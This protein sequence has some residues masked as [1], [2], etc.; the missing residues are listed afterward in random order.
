MITFEELEE[1]I[2][3]RFA[4]GREEMVMNMYL[5]Q[6]K[7]CPVFIELKPEYSNVDKYLDLLL[8]DTAM[9]DKYLERTGWGYVPEKII[10]HCILEGRVQNCFIGSKHATHPTYYCNLLAEHQQKDILFT[11]LQKYVDGLLVIDMKQLVIDMKQLSCKAKDL[12]FDKNNNA[13]FYFNEPEQMEYLKKSKLGTLS[14]HGVG[15]LIGDEFRSLYCKLLENDI[16]SCGK[17]ILSFEIW[18]IKHLLGVVPDKV[19]K[20]LSKKVITKIGESNFEIN[21][22][23]YAVLRESSELRDVLSGFVENLI[24]EPVV[25]ISGNYRFERDYID[26]L[27]ENGLYDNFEHIPYNEKFREAY[28]IAAMENINCSW[29]LPLLQKI[30]T[31]CIEKFAKIYPDTKEFV[32]I[33]LQKRILQQLTSNK[34]AAIAKL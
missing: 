14:F 17:D 8:K 23:Q 22:I 29:A 15:S 3:D 9:C 25:Q 4:L 27:M 19:E 24:F 1:V 6:K 13:L 16:D 21:N 2:S 20:L 12:M 18:A 30:P 28:T 10:E 34:P 32:D 31:D 5:A 11:Y 26:I 33:I 7:V